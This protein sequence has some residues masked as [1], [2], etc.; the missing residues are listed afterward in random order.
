MRACGLLQSLCD[1]LMASGVPADVLT[2]TISAV[3]EVIR[4]NTTNQ[5]FLANVLAPSS[6]PRPVIVVLLMSM[7]NEKQP[8]LLRCAVLYCFQC[9]LYK[10]EVGQS[11][12]VHTLLPQG[13][14][15]PSLT[16]GTNLY[17]ILPANFYPITICYFFAELTVRWF[18]FYFFAIF[19]ISCQSKNNFPI[20]IR[21]FWKISER[22]FYFVNHVFQANYCAVVSSRRIRCPTGFRQL[23]CRTHWLTIRRKK[24]NCWEYS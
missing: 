14:E 10:N 1:I 16:T 9:F 18:T 4:G 13:N 24:S 11:Q 23:P 19:I 20:H 15:T 5:E 7:V 17:E 12:L 8:F 22:D 6:P 2:E 3:A 21:L